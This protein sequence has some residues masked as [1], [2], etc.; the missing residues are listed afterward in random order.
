M[1][2]KNLEKLIWKKAK[3][4]WIEQF[5]DYYSMLLEESCGSFCIDEEILECSKKLRNEIIRKCNEIIRKCADLNKNFGL[6]GIDNRRTVSP[7]ESDNRRTVSS[8]EGND[9]RTVSPNEGNDRR[10]ISPNEMEE[11][12]KLIKMILLFESRI[13]F[14]SLPIQSTKEALKNSF[15]FQEEKFSKTLLMI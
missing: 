10:T 4:G 11:I 5:Y 9:R 3:N 7:N 15:I 13:N 12:L 14:D 8:N 1:F 2:D 6:M